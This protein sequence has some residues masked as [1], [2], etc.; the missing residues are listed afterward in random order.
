MEF[1]IQR[2]LEILERTPGVVD[3]MLRGKSSAWLNCRIKPDAFSP[4]DV[5]GHLI[6]GEMTDW[7]P[8]ARIILE[9]GEMRPF[10]P[11]DRFGHR[12]LIEDRPVEAL[13]DDFAR[14]RRQNLGALAAWPLD[15]SRLQLCGVHPELGR[16]TL[17]QL[18]AT[19]AVHD[20]GH[21]AQIARIMSN[22]YN[23]AVGPWRQYLSILH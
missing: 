12:R 3:A 13:L 1:E 16:V 10:D 22:E 6:F 11:F 17:R 4:V 21:I 18:L 20:L 8:R 15:E 7:I 23:G 9:Q 14:L 5:L 19:W 2:T